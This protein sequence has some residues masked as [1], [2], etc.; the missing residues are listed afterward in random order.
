MNKYIELKDEDIVSLQMWCDRRE[1]E[2]IAEQE[3]LDWLCFG[4]EEYLARK[5]FFEEYPNEPFDSPEF[6]FQYE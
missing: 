2:M 1:H 6:V 5:K 4:E 3:Y